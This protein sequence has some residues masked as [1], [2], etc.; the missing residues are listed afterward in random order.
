[1][2]LLGLPAAARADPQVATI[3]DAATSTPLQQPWILR[4]GGRYPDTNLFERAATDLW[5]IPGSA[6]TWSGA[7]WARFGAV[8]V[9]VAVLSWPNNNPMDVRFQ[10]WV[11]DHKQSTLSSALFKVPTN[12]MSEATVG[13]MGAY[14]GA[15][16]LTDDPELRE[17]VS[18]TSE[19]LV[20]G[21]T[22]HVTTKVML[23]REGPGQGTGRGQYH[24]PTTRYFPGGTPSGHLLTPAVL[25]GV[26]SEYYDSWT[27]RAVSIAGLT[28]M[29]AGSVYHDQH[30]LSDVIWGAT[31]GYGIATW[32]V[33]HRSARYADQDRKTQ[34]SVMPMAEAPGVEVSVT[35]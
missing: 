14:W 23:G 8:A 17:L 16:W 4:V 13:V 22:Y 18:L 20:V 19:A 29:A 15:A 10:D 2:L 12:V 35:F 7:D 3:I 11:D 24:G 30:Y 5:S 32:V 33:H 28:Y 27:L 1:V 34:V 31:M 25:S 21:Q 6:V 26:V 9:P